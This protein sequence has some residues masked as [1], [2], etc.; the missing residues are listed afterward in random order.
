MIRSFGGKAH[1]HFEK[2]D[3]AAAGRMNIAW[4]QE[5][6]HAILRTTAQA[7]PAGAYHQR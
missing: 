4:V 1:A 3:G 2:R 5:S 6:Q 7:F